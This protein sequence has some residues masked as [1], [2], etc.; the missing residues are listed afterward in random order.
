MQFDENSTTAVTHTN[1]QNFAVNVDQPIQYLATVNGTS[2]NNLGMTRL[3]PSMTMSLYWENWEAYKNTFFGTITGSTPLATFESG[4]VI[5]NFVHTV[6]A[7][8]T[9]SL[10]MNKVWLRVTPPDPDPGGAPLILAIEGAILD[11][12]SGDHVA[13]VLV[14]GEPDAR[15]GRQLHPG[16]VVV[17]GDEE[18]RVV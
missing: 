14:N 1:I 11:P 5:L 9:F 18:L 17:V 12:P 8:W 2:V 3:T 16:D 6:N 15:R 4:K 13:P 7:A 10:T